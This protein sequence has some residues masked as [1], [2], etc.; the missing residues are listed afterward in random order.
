MAIP[1]GVTTNNNATD[2]D[3]AFRRKFFKEYV[4]A[5]GFK[6]YM[7]GGEAAMMKPISVMTDNK[8]GGQTT[9]IPLLTKLRNRGAAG[10]S[11]LVGR[12]EPLGKYNFNTK[13][14][15][16][17]HAVATNERDEHYAFAKAVGEVRPM[18]KQF[19]EEQVRDEIIDALSMV[20]SSP[21]GTADA[22]FAPPICN[23]DAPDAPVKVLA[24]AVQLNQ[25]VADNPDRI[26]FGLDN[27][28]GSVA[29]LNIVTG[30]FGAS[31]INVGVNLPKAGAAMIMRM[32]YLARHADP[33]VR[34]IRLGE[35][36][37]EWYVVF[38]DSDAFDQLWSDPDIKQANIEARPRENGGMDKNP[39]FQDGDLLYKGVIIREIPEIR[40][41]PKAVY[42]TAK[43]ICRL[44]LLGAQ[45]IS[46]SWGMEPDFRKRKEDDY[47]FINGVGLVE[48]RGCQK[49]TFALPQNWSLPAG[50]T[51]NVDFGSVTAFASAAN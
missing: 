34:P 10:A 7:G 20:L 8:K 46:F 23:P 42:G 41:V 27:A 30:N 48:A 11:T 3:I 44:H 16:R 43:D 6:P 17:R 37:R 18:L 31:L 51:R 25:W 47:G 35:Q 1:F 39:L 49:I 2:I 26:L 12:E 50:P 22:C 5:S 13:I 21:P 40:K 45:A 36:G 38:A 29:P 4:R 28:V 24:T 33:I 15:W 14:E 19:A 9:R 32:K